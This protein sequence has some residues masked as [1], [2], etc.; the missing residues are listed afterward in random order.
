MLLELRDRLR[1]GGPHS[2][3]DLQA[4]L[5]LTEP[6]VR[7]MLARWMAKGRVARFDAPPTC[8]RCAEK[9]R[10]ED[11]ATGC[12]EIYRWVEVAPSRRTPSV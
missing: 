10:C 6:V 5:G 4:A 7:D 9:G 8:S 1:E 3:A 2:V 11:V 12:F